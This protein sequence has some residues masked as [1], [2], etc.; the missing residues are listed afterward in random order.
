MKRYVNFNDTT[1]HVN[2]CDVSETF[3]QQLARIKDEGSPI[4]AEAPLIYNPSNKYDPRWDIRTDHMEMAQD[5]AQARLE[6]R[7]EFF[8]K[9]T[10]GKEPKEENAQEKV[11]GNEQQGG[12]ET[13]S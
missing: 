2:E 8:K 9:Q 7:R 10:K 3:E 12:G 5:E 11:T 6:K 13:A 4:S 1:L